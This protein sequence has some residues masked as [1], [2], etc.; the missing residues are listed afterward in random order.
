MIETNSTT[1]TLDNLSQFAGISFNDSSA[2]SAVLLNANL[3][4]GIST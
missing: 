2:L 3:L 1:Q 4:Y